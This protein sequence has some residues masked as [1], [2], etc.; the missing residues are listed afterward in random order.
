M[1]YK[2]DFYTLKGYELS[3]DTQITYAM[4]DYLEM[5]CRMLRTRESV[6][7]NEL[8]ESLHVRPS[9]AS[10]MA[11]NLKYMG[12]VSFEKYGHIKITPT[13]ESI[14]DYLLYRHEVLSGLLRLINR[15]Q[16]ETEQVE[17]IEHYLNQDTVRNID[18][19]LRQFKQRDE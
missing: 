12:L 6:R 5:I 13:G 7:I 3:G 11:A 1:D 17:K 4:E 9:S 15:S 8:A 19:F 2:S 14:G 16:D 10:K 18:K